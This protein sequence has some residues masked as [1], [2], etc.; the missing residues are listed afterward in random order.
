MLINIS[1]NIVDYYPQAEQ[2]K[3]LRVL[4]L[5]YQDRHTILPTYMKINLSYRSTHHI[6][7]DLNMQ[8]IPG[9]FVTHLLAKNIKKTDSICQMPLQAMQ[10]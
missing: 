2:M 7:S 9:K 1:K 6:L 10:P 5:V 8:R 3:M 4:F